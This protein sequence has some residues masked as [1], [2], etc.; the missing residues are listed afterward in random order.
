MLAFS[1]FFPLEC[2][3]WAA[4]QPALKLPRNP[5]HL[6]FSLPKFLASQILEKKICTWNPFDVLNYFMSQNLEL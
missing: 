1:I 6:H 3:K 4:E 2:K 5:F